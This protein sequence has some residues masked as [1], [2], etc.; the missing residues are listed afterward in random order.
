MEP[1][2]SPLRASKESASAVAHTVGT[3]A[4]SEKNQI[5][6]DLAYELTNH[7]RLG[8]K[9]AS[10]VLRRTNRIHI[11]KRTASGNRLADRK[12]VWSNVT[13]F[14]T[15]STFVSSNRPNLINRRLSRIC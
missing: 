2:K 9:E 11:A 10:S 13:P 7:D 15:H 12:F 1:E 8:R 5:E 14:L 6:G 4:S 3:Y